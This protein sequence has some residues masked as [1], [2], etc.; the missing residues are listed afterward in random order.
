MTAH[1]N[2]AAVKGGVVD[3]HVH[4]W[5]PARLSY[6]WEAS[7]PSLA[8]P[9]L[10]VDYD[11][12]NG[13]FAV[14]AMV[15]VE[16]TARMGQFEQEVRFIEELAT[17]EPRI[18]AIVMQA[19][20]EDGA[21]V[22]AFLDHMIETTPLL[23]GVRRVCSFEPDP[24]FLLRPE[25]IAGVR[26]LGQRGLTFDMCIHFNQLASVAR[27]ADAV[28]ETR[29]IL[30]HC[31]TTGMPE[32]AADEWTRLLRDVAACG[33]VACKIS[34]IP[35][36]GGEHGRERMTGIVSQ[37]VEIFGFDCI[38]YGGDWPICTLAKPLSA[39]IGL[40]D[41]AL[42]KV[43]PADLTKFYRG[44]AMRFYRLAET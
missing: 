35:W 7:L 33:N 27:F 24:D 38:V 6:I 40:L 21:K 29:L 42:A 17:R 8:R 12:A 25:V 1:S 30:D 20:V 41:H 22:G 23:R 13:D 43:D 3:A 39:W 31:G 11:A 34:E 14:S 16:C 2:V 5:D 32:E 10:P 4:L 9:C 15:F 26:A 36:I 44:N 19:S 28:G 37:V 18:G